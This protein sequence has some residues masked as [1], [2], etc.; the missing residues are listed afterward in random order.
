MRNL[1]PTSEMMIPEEIARMASKTILPESL[2]ELAL[3]ERTMR[4]GHE[5]YMTTI[6]HSNVVVWRKKMEIWHGPV[7][8]PASGKLILNSCMQGNIH[9]IRPFGFTSK[10]CCLSLSIAPSKECFSFF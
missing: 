1:I 5:Q 6:G 10:L 3:W 2:L 9:A 7:T 4:E 8:D